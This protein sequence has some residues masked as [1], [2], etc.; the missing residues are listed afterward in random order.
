M[1]SYT[2]K[3]IITCVIFVL[4]YIVSS[5]FH[6]KGFDTGV[7]T[8]A[9]LWLVV[10]IYIFIINFIEF[11]KNRSI[12]LNILNVLLTGFVLVLFYSQANEEFGGLYSFL[13]L[14]SFALI[15]SIIGILMKKRDSSDFD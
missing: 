2:K 10:A 13:P 9:L 11:N 4:L 5:F 3:V 8:I 12:V 1:Q 14:P 15:P 6:D 7:A